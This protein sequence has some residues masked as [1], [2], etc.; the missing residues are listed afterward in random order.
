MAKIRHETKG[1]QFDILLYIDGVFY[2][3]VELNFVRNT[4]ELLEIKYKK[5]W[6]TI[7]VY[8]RPSRTAPGRTD[9]SRALTGS[10]GTSF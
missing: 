2:P 3:Q 4:L 6:D 1:Y 7:W 8:D 9:T 5:K 10:S